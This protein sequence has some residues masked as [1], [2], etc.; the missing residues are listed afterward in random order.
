[1]HFLYILFSREYWCRNPLSLSRCR[2]EFLRLMASFEK[3]RRRASNSTDDACSLQNH[4][5]NFTPPHRSRNSY[6][7]VSLHKKAHV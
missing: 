1:M 2:L 5:T 3:N 4:I 7:L 6:K